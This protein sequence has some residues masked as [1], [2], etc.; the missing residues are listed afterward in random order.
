[1]PVSGKAKEWD[2]VLEEA[3]KNDIDLMI[4][5]HLGDWTDFP[6]EKTIE[7]ANVEAKR[8]SEYSK[9][10][11]IW[12]AYIN[13]QLANWQEELQRCVDNGAQ[14]IKLWISLK[15]EKGSLK[16]TDSVLKKAVQY[17]LP[18]LLHTYNRTDK[19]R[20]GEIT[21]QEF[22]ELS[23][24]N[25]DCVMIAAH[26]GGNWRYSL[27]TIKECSKNAYLDISGGY[28]ENGMLETLV[29]TDG[30]DRLLFGSDAI[31][32]SFA[33][34]AA[35]VIFANIDEKMKEKVLWKNTAKVYNIKNLSSIKIDEKN[36]SKT[37]KFPLLSE[38]H[39]CF[40]GNW[41]FWE[42][43]CKEPEVLNQILEKNEINKAYTACLDSIFRLDLMMANKKF[44][45][46]CAGFNRI[47]PLAMISPLANNWKNLVEDAVE[48]KFAG[49]F[50][51]PYLHCWKIDDPAYAEFFKLCAE[52]KLKLWINC[53]LAD[54]RFRH[55]AFSPRPVEK[56]ELTNFMKNA[57]VNQYVFQGINTEIITA[58]LK[59]FNM[60]EYFFF[61]FSRLT[62]AQASMRDI[63]KRF[64]IER[65][66]AGS[67]FPFRHI[68]Q[69]RYVIDKL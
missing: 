54:H 9:G 39:F 37:G 18:V 52:K 60:H 14:G 59:L 8:F 2:Y 53:D 24:N 66:V 29:V 5:S 25:P 40:C 58:Q 45:K 26:F 55:N 67:E 65:L 57:P 62:D 6:C 21:I 61:E 4:S 36:N 19:N 68:K 28:P 43:P 10:R 41:P 12:L 35:K 7:K 38:D 20:P 33:S 64:G 23:R 48:R 3:R 49:A 15:D 50:I 63:F 1:V 30:A 44:S 31:G 56:A 47:E 22:A 46:K 32:R 69:T 42:S 11:V 16:N 34:Q 27:G 51:S 17:K 13:P